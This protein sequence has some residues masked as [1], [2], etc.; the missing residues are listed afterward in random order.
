MRLKDQEHVQH[1]LKMERTILLLRCQ[2][3]EAFLNKIEES[4]F[5]V[6]MAMEASTLSDKIRKATPKS[7]FSES[8]Y[9]TF[10]VNMEHFS[11][12]VFSD[13]IKWARESLNNVKD[14]GREYF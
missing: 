9:E 7:I 13:N 11:L 5:D 1:T 14:L 3:L 10:V 6:T 8:E 2:T 4:D 12:A